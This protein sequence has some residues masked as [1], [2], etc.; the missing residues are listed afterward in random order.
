MDDCE[1][2]KKAL[3]AILG[4]DCHA[5]AEIESESNNLNEEFQRLISLSETHYII[6]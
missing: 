2:M 5:L 6:N 1:K 4:Q 3:A